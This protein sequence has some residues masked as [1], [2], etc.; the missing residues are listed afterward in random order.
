MA[1]GIHNS[2]VGKLDAK[3]RRSDFDQS[4]FPQRKKADGKI[5]S[6]NTCQLR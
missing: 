2:F 5:P 4:L 6:K 1:H 3:Q